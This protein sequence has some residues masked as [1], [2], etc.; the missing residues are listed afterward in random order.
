MKKLMTL[1]L[2]LSLVFGTVALVFG[3][4]TTATKETTAKTT[5]AK[6]AK[7]VVKKTEST[8]KTGR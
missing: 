4:D 3:Q 7:K 2:G 6:K 1:M 8:E 5:K